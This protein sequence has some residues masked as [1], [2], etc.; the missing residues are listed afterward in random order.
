MSAARFVQPSVSRRMKTTLAATALAL[1]LSFGVG[2]FINH[3]SAAVNRGDLRYDCRVVF[4]QWWSA[5]Q[6]R[7]WATAVQL[8]EVWDLGCKGDYG[9]IS[10]VSV[11]INPPATKPPVVGPT[12]PMAPRPTTPT[13]TPSTHGPTAPPIAR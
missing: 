6:A 7:D 9:D 4:D 11:K 1:S 3:A 8:K 2:G 10:G 13:P 12:G 5:I